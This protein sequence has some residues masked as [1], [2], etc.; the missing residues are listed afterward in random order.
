MLNLN[1]NAKQLEVE[2]KRIKQRKLRKLTILEGSTVT[3]SL[4]TSK[5]N[6]LILTLRNP[7]KDFV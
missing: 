3:K 1:Y 7:S 6:H 2:K 4:I 5:M